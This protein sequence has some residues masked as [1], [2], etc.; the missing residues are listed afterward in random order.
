MPKELTIKE[1]RYYYS[2]Q[3][4]KHFY[5]WLESIDG[6]DYVRGGPQGLTIRFKGNGLNRSDLFD[7]IA[8]LMRYDLDMRGLRDLVT[9]KNESW[10]KDPQKY[11]YSKIFDD[12]AAKNVEKARSMTRSRKKKL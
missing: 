2:Y 4:E 11:W 7:L 3:D 5:N 9:A 1:S 8:L 10:M 12:D 6:V